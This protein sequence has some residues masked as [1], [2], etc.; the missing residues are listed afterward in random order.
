MER[1]EATRLLLPVSFFPA[2]SLTP[3]VVGS[4]MFGGA[5]Q[6]LFS[7]WAPEPGLW[8]VRQLPPLGK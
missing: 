5:V 8:S 6:T 3:R 2:L 7:S 1:E 4:C